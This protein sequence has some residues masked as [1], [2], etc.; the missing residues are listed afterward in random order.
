MRAQFQ[1]PCDE[2]EQPIHYLQGEPPK[3]ECDYW[4]E[5]Y[6]DPETRT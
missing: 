6:A 2:C 4:N 1:H 3:H 5:T